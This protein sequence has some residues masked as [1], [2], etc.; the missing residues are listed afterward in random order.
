M[1]SFLPLLLVLATTALTVVSAG[2][3]QA[4]L[5][6]LAANAQKPGVVVLPSGLQYKVLTK[7]AGTEHP[8]VDSPCSCHYA[9][10]LIDGT[11]FDS[12]YERGSPTTFAPNQVIKGV[13]V[14]FCLAIRSEGVL[15]RA[16][17]PWNRPADS[18]P[19]LHPLDAPVV[20]RVRDGIWRTGETY[21][22]F[23]KR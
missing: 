6:F 21:R 19:S 23:Y 16:R 7:G 20:R 10:T 18:V 1:G 12:S 15:D 5:D 2:T 8:T 3:N 14:V 13:S 22:P 17:Q 4:G 9:G 11:T